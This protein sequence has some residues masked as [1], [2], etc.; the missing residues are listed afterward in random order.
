MQVWRLRQGQIWW[1]IHFLQTWNRIFPC[2]DSATKSMNFKFHMSWHACRFYFFYM[3]VVCRITLY[4]WSHYAYKV[5]VELGAFTVPET[6]QGTSGSSQAL[7]QPTFTKSCY[8]RLG[9]PAVWVCPPHSAAK[10]THTQSDFIIPKIQLY[11]C[12]VSC[13]SQ[14]HRPQEWCKNELSV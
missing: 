8:P 6:L 3:A 9:C 12:P 5:H 7:K 10:R 2:A 13:S 14:Q 1:T 11:P 4:S